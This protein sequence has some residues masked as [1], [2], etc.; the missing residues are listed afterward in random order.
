[1]TDVA[2]R[3]G[4]KKKEKERKERKYSSLGALFEFTLIS[5][6]LYLSLSLFLS[7]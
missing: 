4:V 7:P 5:F 2:E 3:K 1:M 6:S